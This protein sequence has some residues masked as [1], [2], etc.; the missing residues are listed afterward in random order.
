MNAQS[1]TS[2]QFSE[3]LKRDCLSAVGLI[4][5]KLSP[6]TA[7]NGPAV[8]LKTSKQN[9]NQDSGGRPEQPP[10]DNDEKVDRRQQR[11][12]LQQFKRITVLAS[13]IVAIAGVV[14]AGMNL[15]KHLATHQ[16]T[17]DAYVTGHMHQVSSRINGTVEQ[18]L[19]DD[20]E[21]VRAGQVLVALDK[22]DYQVKVDAALAE[23]RQ[24]QHQANVANSSIAFADASQQG[25]HTNAQ[26]SVSNALATIASAE[27]AVKQANSN[28]NV[29]RADLAA[30]DAELAR[31]QED[32]SRYESLLA[33]GAVSAQQRDVA[34]RDYK[35]AQAKQN[36]SREGVSEALSAMEKSEHAVQNGHAQ[37]T[38]SQAQV[39]LAKA[40]ALQTVINQNQFNV[41]LAAVEKAKAALNEAELNLKYTR[42]VAP[43]SGRI[44]NKTVEAGQR[45]APGQALMTIVS[46]NPW[47]VANFKET[48]LSKMRTGQ[49]VDIKIDSI[50]DHIF[51]GK[52]SSFA[53]ASGASFSVLPS[54]NASGNFTKIVQ[55]VP[56][57]IVLS[58][59]SIIGYEDRIAPGMSAVATVSLGNSPGNNAMNRHSRI[60][61]A[62]R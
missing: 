58:S 49:T 33:Q 62:L 12:R 5:D 21:H 20:N 13:L 52:I 30:K 46:D 18:V 55:R 44:G 60:A 14:I 23:L 48:Q 6:A 43:T 57:K 59:E 31:A 36:A 3:V 28:V 41:A 25:Q 19:V 10:E 53:P 7:P 39:Q 34:L 1:F 50:P 11:T 54:D 22:S 45:I 37:L 51:E 35:V 56:V 47:V 29:A 61:H 40:S 27:A 32:L 16:E 8:V 42:V 38:Q 26:G 24:A 17:D 9:D 2:E 15:Q 4:K